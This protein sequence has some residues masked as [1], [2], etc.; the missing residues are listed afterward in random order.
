VAAFA[1]I[2]GLEGDRPLPAPSISKG[3]RLYCMEAMSAAQV[4]RDGGCS[5]AAVIRRLKLIRN[6]S[7]FTEVLTSRVPNYYNYPQRAIHRWA[8]LPSVLPG[9]GAVECVVAGRKLGLA[10]LTAIGRDMRRLR[11]EKLWVDRCPG[12]T[13]RDRD[14]ATAIGGRKRSGAKAVHRASATFHFLAG[15]QS[16]SASC[17]CID[18]YYPRPRGS[19][20]PGVADPNRAPSQVF[21]FRTC[22]RGAGRRVPG[23][24]HRD[25]A[26]DGLLHQHNSK[27]A[28]V[29]GRL[30]RRNELG[31]A[32]L[33][34]LR[35]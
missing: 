10:W 5:Q 25:E 8:P 1:L 29:A 34:A 27:L 18:R 3:F 26:G 19:G 30:V 32:L 12:R 14:G 2:E 6:R 11:S 21:P 22:S 7:F 17:R 20:V 9:G 16:G 15:A 13:F 24:E 33:P 28:R 31:S 23:L 35:L 4:A